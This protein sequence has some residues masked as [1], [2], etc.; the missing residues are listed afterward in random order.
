[1]KHWQLNVARA[2]FLL[3][4]NQGGEIAGDGKEAADTSGKEMHEPDE[5]L[6]LQFVPAWLRKIYQTCQ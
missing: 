5:R 3:K 1:L 2:G 4:L 6:P